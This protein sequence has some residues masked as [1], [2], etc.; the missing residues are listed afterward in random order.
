MKNL[1]RLTLLGLA[2]IGSNANASLAIKS[3]ELK[4]STVVDVSEIE[5]INV[6]NSD[7]TIESVETTSGVI[8]DGTEVKKVHFFR[9]HGSK[10]GVEAMA[11]KVGG[12]GSGG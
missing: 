10:F 6:H 9:S 2:I 12:E 3:I 5:A 7:S 8:F 1:L 4:N 11:K